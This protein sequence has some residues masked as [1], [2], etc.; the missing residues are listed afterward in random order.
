MHIL[1]KNGYSFVNTAKTEYQRCLKQKLT[2][3]ILQIFSHK[4]DSNLK[5]ISHLKVQTAFCNKKYAQ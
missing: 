5:S 4:H 3:D 2:V 1:H